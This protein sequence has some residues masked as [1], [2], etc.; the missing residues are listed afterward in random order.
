M[1][2]DNGNVKTYEDTE[3]KILG[4]LLRNPLESNSMHQLAKETGLSYVTVFKIIPMLAKKKLI[5]VEKKG[6]SSLVSIDLEKA[7]ISKLSSAILYEKRI[8]LRKHL[9]VHI[10][11]NDIMEKLADELYILV[12]FG[13]Y[14][15]GT[16]KK[17]S[18]IDLLFIVSK[19]ENTDRFKEKINK[20]LGLF[21]QKV[22]YNVIVT[23][24][25]MTML[26]EKYT[27]GWELFRH[28]LVLFG[29]EQYYSMVKKYA[30]T[31]GY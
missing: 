28:S 10:L 30:G 31:K 26:N 14:A 24:S 7:E 19:I 4:K 12:L 23:E 18:D 11:L 16:K 9:D 13:S 25:F 2:K 29:A 21:P 22:E 17:D 5:K 1:K 3:N 15:K 8:F 20:V 27:V 6:K